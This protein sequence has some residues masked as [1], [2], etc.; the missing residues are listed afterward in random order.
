[1][2]ENNNA[3]SQIQVGD[4]TYDIHDAKALPSNADDNY[5]LVI[6]D[7]SNESNMFTVD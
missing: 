5:A 4:V 7:Q 6:K 3:I 2:N 1:M